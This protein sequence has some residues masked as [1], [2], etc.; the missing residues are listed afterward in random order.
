M[1]HIRYQYEKIIFY[2]NHRPFFPNGELLA[3]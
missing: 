2:S 1:C 3:V